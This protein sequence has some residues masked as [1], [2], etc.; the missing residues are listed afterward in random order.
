MIAS[1]TIIKRFFATAAECGVCGL[2]AMCRF[3]DRHMNRM[4][5]AECVI[6]LVSAEVHCRNTFQYMTP[7]DVEHV[8]QS[9][10]PLASPQGRVHW[11]S[12]TE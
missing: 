12:K 8:L 1:A 4:V 7:A 9:L 3:E 2:P 11:N 10:A 6:D 5:C